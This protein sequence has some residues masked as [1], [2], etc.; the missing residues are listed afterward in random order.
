MRVAGMAT[1]THSQNSS[2]ADDADLSLACAHN[3]MRFTS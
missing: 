2:S 3:V 1:S